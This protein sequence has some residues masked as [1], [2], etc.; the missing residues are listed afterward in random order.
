MGNVRLF[1]MES[2]R[3]PDDSVTSKSNNILERPTAITIICV[4]EFVNSGLK[5]IAALVPAV[6]KFGE[7]VPLYLPIDAIIV[8]ICMIGVWRMK[9]WGLFAFLFWEL[10][11]QVIFLTAGQWG[12]MHLLYPLLLIFFMFGYYSKMK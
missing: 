11:V 12:P 6:K 2:S 7:W 10:T 5:F 3:M 8:I 4:L 1:F 9:K